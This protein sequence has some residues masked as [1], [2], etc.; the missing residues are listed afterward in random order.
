VSD[1]AQ[2]LAQ[3]SNAIS[4][5][6]VAR[7]WRQF[8]SPRYLRSVVLLAPTLA[9]V[10]AGAVSYGLILK[11]TTDGLAAG[12][13]RVLVLAPIAV[14]GATIVRAL[15][16][17]GQ[18]VQSQML[19][20]SVLRDLQNAMFAKLMS[21]D[22]VRLAREAPASLVSRF[23]NDVNIIGELL[24][25]GG[26][27][28]IRDTLTLLGAIATMLWLDW[29]LSLVVLGVF[30]LAAPALGAIAKRARRQT[31][32]AQ[33]QLGA[34][35]ATL[36][37][38]F[39]AARL[40]KTYALEAHETARAE[41]A[42]ETRRKLARKLAY[43]R[44][45]AV[46]LLE[47]IGGAALAGV[48]WIAA[49]RIGAEAMTLGDLIGIIGAV[50]AATPSARAL[51]QANTLLNEGRAALS[52]I[53]TLLDEPTFIND[54]PGARAL[55][56]AKGRIEFEAVSFAY[57]SEP[58]LRNVNF[59]VSP[60]E[61]VALVGPSGAGK[62]TVFN[63]LPRLYDVTSGSVRIDGQDVRD[64]T[65]ASLRAAMALVTQEA[66]LFHDSVRAN[67]ALGRPGATQAEIE[68]AA[69]AAA[70][71]DFIMALPQGYDTNVGD[72]G[73]AISGGERQRIALARA[74]LRN[75]P[76]LLLDEAT[77]ALDAASEARVQ[78]ALTRLSK[79]R[80]VLVIAHRLS[81]V[82]DA[83][84]I[85]VFNKGEIVEVGC[86]DDLVS[87]GGVYTELS[88]LQFQAS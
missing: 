34:L 23:T 2:A 68:D 21:V 31:E 18:A 88:R 50:A 6:S 52:R 84:R 29:V 71:H 47:I 43:N 49:W 20:L 46:P 81:T 73:S 53:F 51:G 63:L 74:F 26:Q 42:F 33:A 56:T 65:L 9:L 57:E 67:I 80:T 19:S 86:H 35:S 14:L 7:L 54:R 59:A 28:I 62:S 44:A 12:D 85:L 66:S 72:R 70:A 8:V 10:A 36:S 25:R 22:F 78:D 15:A 69:R 55:T 60:G 61:T 11:Y 37:E 76:I 40:V 77:S 24:V 39:A 16:M 48:L 64:V 38:S 83:D 17:W 45:G 41:A 30:A 1:A 79:G 58:A 87:R 75:A 27:A 4:K 3:E 32:A 5:G 82:R 13:P